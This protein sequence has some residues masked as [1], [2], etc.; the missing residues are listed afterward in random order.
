MNQ[1]DQTFKTA[2]GFNPHDYQIRLSC[3]EQLEKSYSDWASSN[4]SCESVLIDI[5]TGFGKTSAVVLA[6]LWNRVL[7]QN[8]DWPRR[9]VY[10]LPMRTLVEQTFQNAQQWVANLKLSSEVG[11]HMLMGGADAGEWD[12]QVDRNM[13]LIGTQDMLL[14]RALNRGYG[15][16]RYRWPMHF[17]LLNNDCLWVM[18]EVQLMGPGLRTSAQLD[19][20]RNDRFGTLKPCITWW[21]SATISQKFLETSDRKTSNFAVPKKIGLSKR[22]KNHSIHHARRPCSLWNP[23]TPARSKKSSKNLDVKIFFC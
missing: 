7:K 13:I 15:M 21:M 3:G 22:D 20:M 12:V 1:F 14:S 19:W 23:P 5:P 4:I 10:C 9:L 11:I 16:S 18:D 8:N 6:W 17:G 2:T